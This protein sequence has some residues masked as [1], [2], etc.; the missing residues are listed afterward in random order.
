[1][2]LLVDA[3]HYNGWATARLGEVCRGLS[4][5]E[6]ETKPG[7]LHESPLG[8]L[9]HLVEVELAYLAL[10]GIHTSEV[11]GATLE[12]LLADAEAAAER[13]TAFAAEATEERL[14]HRFHMSRLK[15]DFTVQD[16]L[17]QVLAHSASHRAELGVALSLLGRDVPG[18]DYVVYRAAHE[19]AG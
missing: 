17:L 2:K 18:T 6:L 5:A 14:A 1:M 7:G 9:Q 13:Y 8:L 3:F 15:A 10:T 4:P 16:A 12:H 11:R 19:A